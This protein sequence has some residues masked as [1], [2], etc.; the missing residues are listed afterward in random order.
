[1]RWLDGITDS[2]DVSFSKL[3]ETVKDREAGCAAVQGVAKSKSRFSDWTT[4]TNHRA[5]KNPSRRKGRKQL[6]GLAP[7]S[8][9]AQ[10]VNWGLYYENDFPGGS[11]V[12][13]PP[14]SA[15]DGGSIPGLERCPGE[16][17]GN[18]LQRSCLGNPH[19]QRSL[20]DYSLRGHK[21]VGHDLATKQQQQGISVNLEWEGIV[22]RVQFCSLHLSQ[23]QVLLSS[24]VL[25]SDL[26][27][28]P[29]A[30]KHTHR[31]AGICFPFWKM[32]LIKV[33]FGTGQKNL[34]KSSEGNE[35]KA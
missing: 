12:N 29:C 15:G 10:S 24:G 4:T 23:A 25:C 27:T 6:D 22:P 7:L 13:N 8:N 34:N 1:M 2:V 17:N 16:G 20:G 28:H 30:H 18:P 14:A 21:R 9:R 11:V 33:S 31:E 26:N 5:S 3:Q 19:G 32:G 35:S